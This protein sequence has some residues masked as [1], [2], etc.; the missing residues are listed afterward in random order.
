M[1]AQ[2]ESEAPSSDC[3]VIVER[4][5]RQLKTSGYA[6]GTLGV[7]RWVWRKFLK[8]AEDEP[9]SPAL[10]DRFLQSEG[11]PAGALDSYGVGSQR[12]YII[13]AMRALYRYASG[14]PLRL[15]R[16]ESSLTPLS[17]GMETVLSRYQCYCTGQRRLGAGTVQTRM[18]TIRRF[19]KFVS[20][21]MGP[22]LEDLR[23]GH[24]SEFITA[25]SRMA[26]GTAAALVRLLRDFLRFL[27]ASEIVAKDL[28]R[29][30]PKTRG[31][32]D[33][34]IPL[35]WTQ[36]QVD[37][38]LSGIDRNSVRGKRDHAILLLACRVGLRSK[39]IRELALENL[40][41]A[42]SRIEITQA[43]TGKTLAL[44]MLDDVGE[45][46]IDYLRN[47]RPN[48]PFR[49]VFLS[50][51]APFRP[52]VNGSHLA[53]M[54]KHYL[55]CAGIPLPKG[56]PVGLH[57]L[58]HTLA[59]RMLESSIPLTTISDVLG[60]RSTETT[61]IYT[62]VDIPALRSVSLDPDA[63]ILKEAEHV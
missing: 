11:Y 5:A 17:A 20:E 39:D 44:P 13:S 62:K 25:R 47:G 56:R 35:V 59:T 49:Q 1:K 51:R 33:A 63:M 23:A 16:R 4:A 32:K 2:R 46:L 18:G 9:F 8:F 60:H 34:H 21:R 37:A 45:A 26:P 12:P 53:N 14:A 42:E 61:Y 36:E 28:S 43:K 10:V 15:S 27:W 19:L 55:E 40:F 52:L 22:R 24:I 48:S 30:L 3:R 50:V 7:Y 41:W 57:S 54:L 29:S 31:P 6:S 38:L 58:R